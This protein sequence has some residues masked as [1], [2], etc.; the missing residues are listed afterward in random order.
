MGH[1]AAPVQAE[2]ATPAAPASLGGGPVDT[3]VE[4]W[5][6]EIPG[7]EATPPHVEE[8]EEAATLEDGPVWFEGAVG[9]SE[10]G[11][12]GP[13]RVLRP[14]RGRRLVP[15]APARPAMPGDWLP[16]RPAGAFEVPGRQLG[17]ASELGP[18]G[19]SELSR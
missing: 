7:I 8:W 6:A 2:A 12:S 18:G 1:D 9:S 13:S 15:G 4:V 11:R 10:L 14:A 19:A 16:G 3:G 5:G 17:G